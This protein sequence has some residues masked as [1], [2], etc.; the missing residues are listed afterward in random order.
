MQSIISKNNKNKFLLFCIDSGAYP[1]SKLGGGQAMVLQVVTF[2]HGK[3]NE[4]K[5][6]GKLYIIIAVLYYSSYYNYLLGFLKFLF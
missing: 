1:G 6:L 5:I 4:T 2:Q 3:A